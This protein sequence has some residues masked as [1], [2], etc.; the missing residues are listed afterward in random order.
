MAIRLGIFGGTFDPPHLAH[1]ILAGEAAY[2]L[3]LDRVLWVLTADPPHKENL[4]VSP[5]EQRQALVQAAI[6]EDP[7]FELSRVDLD[8]PPPHFAFETVRL[9]HARHPGATLIYLMG[10]DSL[11]DLPTWKLPDVFISESDT[12]GVMRRPGDMLNLDALERQL[13]GLT[14]KV[15][16]MDAPLVA[17]SASDIRRRVANGEPVRYFLPPAVYQLII[18]QGWYGYR[19]VNLI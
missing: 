18:R 3:R 8:R 15:V 19:G 7:I 1:L 5:W 10:G 2:Q 16:F 13:P 12:I 9:L 6:K 11:H 4:V 17:I 14:E